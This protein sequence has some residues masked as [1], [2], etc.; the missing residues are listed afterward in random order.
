MFTGALTIR[1]RGEG[2]GKGSVGEND[3]LGH[4]KGEESGVKGRS[5]RGNGCVIRSGE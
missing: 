1:E 3:A 5:E 4:L 2:E